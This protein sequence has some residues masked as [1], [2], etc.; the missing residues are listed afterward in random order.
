MYHPTVSAMSLQFGGNLSHGDAA[1]SG[2]SLMDMSNLLPS[3]KSVGIFT[4]TMP[5]P[6]QVQSRNLEPPA[7]PKK[8]LSPYMTFSKEVSC[9]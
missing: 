6:Q 8:P 4:V 9:V 7:P 3:S 1:G 5:Q 2:V